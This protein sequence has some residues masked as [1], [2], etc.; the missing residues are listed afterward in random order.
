MMTTFTA[1]ALPKRFIGL[2]KVEL[3]EDLIAFYWGLE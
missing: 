2:T 1:W 3:D